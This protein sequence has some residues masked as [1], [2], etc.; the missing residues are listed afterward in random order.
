MKEWFKKCPYCWKEIK[1]I[2]IKCQ[3]CLKF[4]NQ[5]PE[6]TTKECPFCLNEIDIN[7]KKCP[8]CDEVLLRKNKVKKFRQ[9]MVDKKISFLFFIAWIILISLFLFVFKWRDKISWDIIWLYDKY[10]EVSCEIFD[11]SWTL[12]WNVYVKNNKILLKGL[13]GE[14]IYIDENKTYGWWGNFYEYFWWYKWCTFSDDI[15][16]YEWNIID[17]RY[18]LNSLFSWEDS[19]YEPWALKCKNKVYDAFDFELPNYC[20]FE[21]EFSLFWW[22]EFKYRDLFSFK[23][24]DGLIIK[25]QI[26]I[27]DWFNTYYDYSPNIYIHVYDFDDFMGSILG[28]YYYDTSD[29]FLKANDNEKKEHYKLI[30]ENITNWNWVKTIQSS[31]FFDHLSRYE[32]I[33]PIAAHKINVDWINWLLI[34]Y[35]FTDDKSKWCASQFVT[36]LLLVK[37]YNEIISIIF[38]NNFWAVAD[39]FKKWWFYFPGT[40]SYVETEQWQFC[41]KTI[42]TDN[43]EEFY[44]YWWHSWPD[45][46]ELNYKVIEEII[47]TIKF[48]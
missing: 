38:K 33:W 43:I 45:E 1:D 37:N 18:V 48:I 3:Y 42:S 40:Y 7:E 10:W 39:L 29:F 20:D 30:L 32:T 46:F 35:Y 23:Y 36:E 11:D 25:N 22:K 5:E 15:V 47:R 31:D 9:F 4:L 21:N 13:D 12:E 19:F 34:N 16:D 28:G 17:T 24:P 26:F 14:V 27:Y 41:D 2:A 8:F 6:K 44:K